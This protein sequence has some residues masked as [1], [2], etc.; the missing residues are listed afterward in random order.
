MA[1][2]TCGK[3]VVTMKDAATNLDVSPVTIR[4]LI[5]HHR[6]ETLAIEHSPTGRGI[7]IA[8]MA[9]LRKLLPLRRKRKFRLAGANGNGES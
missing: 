3:Q 4:D 1:K 9:A 5:R 6:I 7:P 8:G 2:S